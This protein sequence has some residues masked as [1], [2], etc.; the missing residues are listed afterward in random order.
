MEKKNIKII[1]S[2]PTHEEA[3]ALTKEDVWGKW[4]RTEQG[5]FRL[6]FGMIVADCRLGGFNEKKARSKMKCPIFNDYVDYKSVTVLCGIE[7]EEEVL[8]WLEYVQGGD[9]VSQ[10]KYLKDT[11]TKKEYVA[12]R[13]DYQCW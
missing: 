6:S 7:W 2:E 11:E 12:I 13:G 8:Y 3:K 1:V 9:C 10:T 4:I 5:S